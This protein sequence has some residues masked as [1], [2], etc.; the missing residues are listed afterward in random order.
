[1][2]NLIYILLAAF[3]LTSCSKETPSLGEPFSADGVEIIVQKTATQNVFRFIN[4][5]KDKALLPAG[6]W[7]T[8][9][10]LPETP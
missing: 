9:K 6:P 4:G 10:P 5:K 8:Q 2:K 1:M 7:E 3:F